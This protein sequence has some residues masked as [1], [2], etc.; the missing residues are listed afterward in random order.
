MKFRKYIGFESRYLLSWRILAVL[1]VFFYMCGY[2]V[3]Y[4]LSQY[5]HIMQERENF[6]GFEA[7]KLKQFVYINQFGLYGLR[8]LFAPSPLMAFF[9][10]GPVPNLMTAFIDTSERMKIYQPLKSQNAF[11][12]FNNL[13]MNFCGFVLFFGSTLA[14]FYGYDAFRRHAWLKFL[15]SKLKSRKKLYLY[16]IGSRTAILFL[17]CLLLGALS[18]L[19]FIINGVSVNLGQVLAYSL[20]FFVLLLYFLVI[21]FCGGASKSKFKGVASMVVAWFLLAFI[22]PMLIYQW[23]FS[24]AAKIESAYNMEERKL[25][26]FMDYERT[27]FE[28]EGKFDASKRGSQKEKDMFMAFW[29]RGFKRIMEDEQKMINGIKDHI[30][31]YQTLA[32]LFP[33]TFFL[34]FSGEMSSQGFSSMVGF[35]EY[36]QEVKKDFFWFRAENFIFSDQKEFQPF[37]KGEDDNIYQGKSQLPNNFDFGLLVTVLWLAALFYS[38]WIRFKRILDRSRDTHR[39]LSPDELQKDKVNIIFTQDKG[40]LSQL[41]AK[42]K[43]QNIHFLFFPGPAS[44]PG[45]TKVKNLFKLFGLTVPET[46]KKI[47]RKYVYNLDPDPEKNNDQKGKVLSEL[48]RLLASDVI[49]FDRFLAGLSDELIYHFAGVLNSIKK[50]RIVVYFTN[51]LMVTVLIQDCGIKWKKE[52]MTF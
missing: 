36:A 19:L 3:N 21:G 52:K 10:G 45:D 31:Y 51:S 30:S 14:L 27:S 2:F 11:T 6:Q 32:A 13:F 22:I 34:S 17:I 50:G 25:K 39:E 5:K 12:R 35:N 37:F 28:E 43:A 1:L 44:L 47:A 18:V 46:L 48:I 23:T 24:E 40:V 49:I 16:I 42:L 26:E 20:G 7:A 4:G 33:T 8:L 29:N 15:E 38:S 41:I 9:D